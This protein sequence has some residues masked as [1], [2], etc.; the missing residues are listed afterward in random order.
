MF[1]DRLASLTRLCPGRDRRDGPVARRDASDDLGATK[2][3]ANDLKRFALPLA[4]SAALAGERLPA[5]LAAMAVVE[6]GEVGGR[7]AV[8]LVLRLF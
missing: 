8:P 3:P 6:V 5:S 2:P 7:G 4:N 1:A